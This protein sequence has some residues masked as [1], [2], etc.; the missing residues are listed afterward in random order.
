MS[1][2]RLLTAVA[3]LLS[4][5]AAGAQAQNAGDLFDDQVLHRI[6]L[7]VNSRD[8]QRLVENFTTNDYYPADLHWRD[9]TVRNVGIRSRGTGSRSQT[10][11]GLLVA[12]DHYTTGQRFL[13]MQALVLKNLT[14][15]PSFIH[16]STA[17]KFLRTMGITAPRESFAVVYVNRTYF[18]VYAL[19]EDVNEVSLPRFVGESTGYLFEYRW[20]FD[21]HFEYLG[22]DLTRYAPLF[23]PRTRV[24]ESLQAFYGPIEAMVRTLND[25]ADSDFV[26]AVSPY[27][28]LNLFVRHVAVQDF[29]AENDGILGYAGLNNFYLYRF[30]GTTLHQLIP[31][32]KDNAFISFTHA[33][34]QGHAENVLMRRAMQ[35]PDLRAL[36]FNTLIESAN[37]ADRIDEGT[38]Q[39]WLE[40][41]VRRQ[42]ALIQESALNDSRKPFTNDEFSAASSA[43]LQFAAQRSPFVRCE[44]ARVRGQSCQ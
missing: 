41:E 6:D 19:V 1:I 8:W 26:S 22:S 21:Y 14:Q 44:V 35:V 43:M 36:Y 18:G 7:Y 24:T 3:V 17:M 30:A 39:G 11:L 23:A 2:R 38:T 10:K 27:L 32:D 12:V 20:M 15:D 40:R 4:L 29:V 16:E 13:G 33:I 42:Q 5:D 31:W 34:L 37:L 25:V 9:V 28:D